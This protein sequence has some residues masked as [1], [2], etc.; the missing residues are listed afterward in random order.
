MT[1]PFL[2]EGPLPRQEKGE[3]QRQSG[4]KS[5]AFPYG[6]V[7]G[8]SGGADS[9][10]MFAVAYCGALRRS[11]ISIIKNRSDGWA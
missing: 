10:I 5:L 11:V 3:G 9:F 6:A 1:Y 7:A 4:E 2:T 8:Y